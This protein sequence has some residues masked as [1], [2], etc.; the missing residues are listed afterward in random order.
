MKMGDV[1][2]QFSVKGFNNGGGEQRPAQ[3]DG[4][5]TPGTLRSRPPKVSN[6]SCYGDNDEQV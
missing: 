3:M 6:D 1:K 4:P 5:N 2:R